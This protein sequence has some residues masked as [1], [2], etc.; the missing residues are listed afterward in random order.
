MHEDESGSRTIVQYCLFIGVAALVMTAAV[1]APFIIILESLGACRRDS[2]CSSL[3][4]DLRSSRNFTVHPCDDFYEHVCGGWDRIPNKKFFTPLAKYKA[5]FNERRVKSVVYERIPQKPERSVHKASLL[6]LSCLSQPSGTQTAGLLTSYLRSLHM[7]WPHKSSASRQQLLNIMVHASLGYALPAVWA[8][9]VG[10]NPETPSENTLYMDLD[11]S[12]GAFIGTMRVLVAKG[13]AKDFL[14]LCAELIGGTGQSY[15]SMIED[16]LA[17]HKKF[18]KILPRYW[19]S[20]RVPAYMSMSDENLRRAI[21]SHLPDNSQLWKNDKIVN[22]QLA[23]FARFD[24]EFLQTR[25]ECDRFKLYLGAY[26]VWDLSP[27][28]SRYLTFRMMQAIDNPEF[29]DEYIM[30]RC[31]DAVIWVMPMVSWKMQDDLIYNKAPAFQA[32]AHA[33][34]SIEKFSLK[35]GEAARSLVVQE[36]EQVMMNALNTTLTSELV[37][38]AYSFLSVSRSELFFNNFLEVTSTSVTFFKDSLRK[39]IHGIPYILGLSEVKMYRMLVAREAT[40]FSFFQV[41]PLTLPDSPFQVLAAV[42]GMQLS[43]AMLMLLDMVFFHGE[44]FREVDMAEL[45][46]S[47]IQPM[48]KDIFTMRSRLLASSKSLLLSSE[49]RQVTFQSLSAALTYA[50]YKVHFA[51][52]SAHAFKHVRRLSFDGIPPDQLFFLVHCFINCGMAGRQRAQSIALCNMAL[53][54]VEDF[55]EAFKCSPLH[56]LA[57][58]FSWDVV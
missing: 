44:D 48:L 37:D 21:N 34:K 58:N 29:T 10:R 19:N 16:V 54:A 49:Q 13:T 42:I 11:E 20:L 23:L 4:N 55:K 3:E 39:P 36:T 32:L 15:S 8:F 40:V 9:Y 30:E 14:R 50:T 2:V 7:P 45:A 22:I 53:P 1:V 6:L 26:I 38:K 56:P 27:L 28:T 18:S 52:V 17:I 46:S 24:K 25:Q 43:S 35:Y 5:P 47:P 31:L 33:K 57:F 41:P 12:V 51:N